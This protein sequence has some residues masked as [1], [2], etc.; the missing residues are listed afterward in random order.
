M[1]K[2][3]N[4]SELATA[5]SKAYL[6]II[7]AP[8]IEDRIM[9]IPAGSYVSI[10]CS[11][12]HGIEPTL[13]LMEALADR[14]L[15]LI[16]HIAA[17]VI[18]DKA[19]LREILTRLQ[20]AGISSVFCPGGDAA[21]AAGIYDSSLSLL[22]D[23]ADIGHNIRSVGVASHPEG[24]ALVSDRELVEL[25][26]QKQE[27]ANYLVTQMCFDT[28]LL[29]RWLRGIR[30]AGVSLR[31]WIGLPGVAD[32]TKL[33][34]LSMRIGVGQSA[35]MLMRQKDLL[36]KMLQLKPYQPDE[37][38]E[39]LAPYLSDPVLDIPSFHLFSFNDV[40]RTE[41]WRQEAVERYSK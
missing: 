38:V 19:H 37:L 23:M 26:L 16:P 11:P 17:R 35:K 1:T 13:E 3:Q 4:N 20:D 24:H 25:L 29:I 10:T 18:K 6:E 5:L 22:R 15:K 21:Q 27:I 32:R 33:F 31:A 9:P 7:P 30:E 14:D 2:V 8:G 40:E 34:K 39:Q 12:V 28:D 41:K 36:K